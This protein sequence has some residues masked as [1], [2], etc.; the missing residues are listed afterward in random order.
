MVE[1]GPGVSWPPEPIRSERLVLRESEASDRAAVIKLFTSP[2]VGTYIG[3]PRSLDELEHAM[4]DVPM[5]RCGL[6]VADLNEAMIG[7]VTLYRH[8]AERLGHLSAE[9]GGDVELGYMF[10]PEAWGYGYATEA[11]AAVLEWFAG[12]LPGEQVV[13]S[14]QTAN[15][16]S[17]RVAAKLGFAEVERFEEFGAEQW[18][19]VWSTA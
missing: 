16:G 8:D 9:G 7:L 6:F 3:G 19:G 13:L 10:L 11:C 18:F 12:V 14:T 15:Q 5:R 2:E 1:L 4:P 17:M